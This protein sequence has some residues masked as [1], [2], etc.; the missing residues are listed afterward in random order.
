MDE[1]IRVLEVIEATTAG[2][3]KHVLSLV[4]ALD[5]T[6]FDVAVACPRVRSHSYGDPSFVEEL[7][8]L[9]EITVSLVEMRRDIQPLSDAK[10]LVAL[11]RV[12]QEGRYHIVHAHSSK[13]GVLG[14][15]AAKW[16][17]TPVIL[18]TPHGFAFRSVRNKLIRWAYIQIERLCGMWTDRIICVSPTE[19][20]EALRSRIVPA[21]KL[22]VIENGLDLSEFTLLPDA[23]AKK[24]Q[25]GLDP[26]GPIVGTMGRLS[27]DK[28]FGWFLEAAVEVSTA[29]PGTQFLVVGDGEARKDLELLAVELGI[30]SQTIFTG[31]LPDNLEGLAL[32]DIIVLPSPYEA[33]PYTVVAAMASAEPVIALEGPGAQ[34]AVQRG[35]TG[36]LVPPRN[37]EALVAAIIALLRGKARAQAMGFAG[38]R[39]VESRFTLTQ[40]VCHTEKL[41]KD[42][43]HRRLVSSPVAENEMVS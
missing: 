29:Y 38:R 33:L 17:G 34:D 26:D 19:R 6:C 8:S 15:L 40:M 22:V 37:P 14:R 9:R 25:V 41:Y 23:L 10:T 30:S 21:D 24:R 31:F 7:K 3:K 28:G 16:A 18:Y 5:R 11:C 20:Q 35:E 27:W 4:K 2:A 13:A 32:M 1:R 43:L 39:V 12:I 42:L 36:L